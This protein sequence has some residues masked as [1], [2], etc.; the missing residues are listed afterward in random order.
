MKMIKKLCVMLFLSALILNLFSAPAYAMSGV[1]MSRIK[2][3]ENEKELRFQ[4]GDIIIEGGYVQQVHPFT[5]AEVEKLARKALSNRGITQLDLVEA[6]RA[7]E[8]AKRAVEF[9]SE[10]Y[11]EWKENMLTTIGVTG[12]VPGDVLTAIEL[13]N[14]YMTSK[15]WDD[16][17]QVSGEFLSDQVKD[18]IKDT[19]KGYIGEALNIASDFE[20]IDEWKDKITKIVEFAEV[21]ADSHARTKQKWKDIGDG[22]NA[23]RLLNEFYTRFQQEVENYMRKS[24]E[25]GWIIKFDYRSD[26][27]IFSFF[28]VPNN[29]Q[30][31]SLNMDMNKI[32]GDAFGSI[33][34]TYKGVYTVNA[35]HNMDAFKN[36]TAK[37]AEKMKPLT[38]LQKRYDANKEF[39][40]TE[41][42]SPEQNGRVYIGRTICGGCTAVIDKSG[43]ISLT[44]NEDSDETTVEFS[45]VMVDLKVTAVN[46][47]L[48][49]IFNMT[50]PIE[51]SN[52]KQELFVNGIGINIVDLQPG[53]EVDEQ[54]TGAGGAQS[55]G[56]DKQIWKHWDRQEKRLI[57][58][59]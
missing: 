5:E 51:I 41:F 32:Q 9:T 50:I 15:S 33:A 47:E 23:K 13:A 35:E 45:G 11:E 26:Y 4:F 54:F 57:L 20:L 29:D 30:T 56:W 55:V 59:D 49:D 21:M 27:R 53:L 58:L 52:E 28:G 10:D 12:V 7:I 24:D 6:N 44:L 8:K 42:V 25:A 1:D 48:G 36:N 19:A 38:Q 43:E 40:R 2:F 17:G 18:E 34:G 31:W 16:I 22:A 37:A 3:S 39:Y 46:K 14:K